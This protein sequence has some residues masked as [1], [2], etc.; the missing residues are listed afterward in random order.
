MCNLYSMVT[1]QQAI[2][3]LFKVRNDRTGNLPSLPEIFPDQ[4]APIV[5]V[6]TDGERELTMARWG[7]R[8]G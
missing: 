6:A 8:M 4:Q 3:Q 1:N 2:R 5:R 7:W